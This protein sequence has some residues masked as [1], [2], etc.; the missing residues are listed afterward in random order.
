MP[1]T[2]EEEESI[3][4]HFAE[5][6][7]GGRC[8]QCGFDWKTPFDEARS[9]I[10]NAPG[11]YRDRIGDRF[12]DARTTSTGATWSP[13]A[14]VWHCADILGIW[15]ERLK[16]LADDPES[17]FV[18]FDQDDLAEVRGYQKLSPVA[19]LWAFE[20]RVADWNEVLSAHD[21]KDELDHPDLGPWTIE[22]IVVWL[23]HE[24]RH[25]EVDIERGL[26]KASSVI[27]SQ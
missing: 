6:Q 16:A 22:G 9:I 5:S 21:P 26:D 7:R 23:A 10:S 13:S 18:G 12:E 8:K 17:P 2:Q 4:G 20:R 3:M 11:R 25:H 1:I 24:C 14:Y 27:P 15:A 19:G